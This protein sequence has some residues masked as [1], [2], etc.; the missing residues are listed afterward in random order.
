MGKNQSQTIGG[1]RA[2]YILL[3]SDDPEWISFGIPSNLPRQE[4]GYFM[5]SLL[6]STALLD[7]LP[8]H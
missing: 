8:L 6:S 1:N 3:P 5:S 4:H 7:P 2:V